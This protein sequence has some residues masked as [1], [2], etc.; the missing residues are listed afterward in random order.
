MRYENGRKDIEREF[1]PDL[2]AIHDMCDEMIRFRE[3]IKPLQRKGAIKFGY[4]HC[5]L[6]DNR[7][8]RFSNDVRAIQREVEFGVLGRNE[9][10]IPQIISL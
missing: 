6:A 9:R 10:A 1:G 3:R 8:K 5:V 4:F 7:W 2:E